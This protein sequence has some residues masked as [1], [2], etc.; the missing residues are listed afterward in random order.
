MGHRHLIE[1]GQDQEQRQR[2]RAGPAPHLV[3]ETMAKK[4][5]DVTL[6]WGYSMVFHGHSESLGLF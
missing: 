2:Q 1:C 5:I 6:V 4:Y 3:W